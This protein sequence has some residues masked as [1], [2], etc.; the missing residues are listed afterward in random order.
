LVFGKDF[1]YAKQAF[2]EGLEG[3]KLL[4]IAGGDGLA[5]RDFSENLQGEQ[6][7]DLSSKMRQNPI[8][9]GFPMMAK[10]PRKDLPNGSRSIENLN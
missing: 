4:I 10:Y 9:P 6:Y 2:L 1:I 5:C 3:K 8:I 7:R